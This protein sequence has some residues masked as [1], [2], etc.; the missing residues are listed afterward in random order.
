MTRGVPTVPHRRGRLARGGVGA[1]GS[2]SFVI[3]GAFHG[4]LLALQRAFGRPGDAW[5]AGVRQVGMFMLVLIGWVL[6]RATTWSMAM[7]IYHRM[8]APTAGELVEQPVLAAV[9][10]CVVAW[11]AMI[12][13]NVYELNLEPTPP[14]RFALTAAFGASLAIII[15]S[16]FSPFLY[17]QF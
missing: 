4:A 15:G 8:F 6:F 9:V 16:P 10:L 17:F 7:S 12:G 3:G 2:G 1:G 13:P 14:R 11:W 5:N